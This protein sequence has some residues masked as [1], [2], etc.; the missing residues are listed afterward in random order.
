MRGRP[1]APRTIDTPL[2]EGVAS[3]HY[4]VALRATPSINLRPMEAAPTPVTRAVT[5]EGT[6]HVPGIDALGAVRPLVAIALR[7]SGQPAPPT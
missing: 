3:T 4:A 2:V 5:G 1:R 7:A 6:Q